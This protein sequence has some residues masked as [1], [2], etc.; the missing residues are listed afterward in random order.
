MVKNRGQ[1]G[2]VALGIIYIYLE[3]STSPEFFVQPYIIYV[4]DNFLYDT[5]SQA[6]YILSK[7]HSVLSTVQTLAANDSLTLSLP[8]P[9]SHRHLPFIA[10]LHP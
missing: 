9:S 10:Y 1:H 5:Y 2:L 3:G 8:T 6:I 4:Y 7:V